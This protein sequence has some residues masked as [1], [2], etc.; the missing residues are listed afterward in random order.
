MLGRK[1]LHQVATIVTPDTTLRWYR[2][3]VAKKMDHAD[4]RGKVGRP[5]IGQEVVTLVLRFARMIFFGE[6][7]LRNAVHAFCEHYHHERNHQGLNNRLID[8]GVEVGRREGGV[9]CRE[10]LGGMLR[11]YYRRAAECARGSR[12]G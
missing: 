12:L 11:Y 5:R 1:L 4:R 6:R 8:P 7:S 3:L 10:R 9:V 2:M